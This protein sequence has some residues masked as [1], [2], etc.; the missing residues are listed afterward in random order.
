MTPE[1]MATTVT[2]TSDRVPTAAV[3]T[4]SGPAPSAAM[5]S[6]T[7]TVHLVYQAGCAAP[8]EARKP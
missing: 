8:I 4:T 6:A 5:A 1:R 2:S 3:A 7:A